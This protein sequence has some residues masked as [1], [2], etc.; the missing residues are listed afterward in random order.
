ML[1]YLLVQLMGTSVSVCY[2]ALRET[3]PTLSQ[4][5][6]DVWK[7]VWERGHLQPRIRLFLWKIASRALPL[8]TALAARGIPADNYHHSCGSEEEDSV[9]TFFLCPFARACWYSCPLPIRSNTLSDS[10][11]VTIA[12]FTQ[13]LSDDQ[14]E[15]FAN[16][17]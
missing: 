16:V 3:G 7:T 10:F 13:T 11:K 1:W 15:I 14:W 5:D 17:L 2:K 6:R 8:G 12:Q 4:A 9:H